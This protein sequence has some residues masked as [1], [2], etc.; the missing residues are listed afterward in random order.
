MLSEILKLLEEHGR[1]SLAEL[2]NHFGMT[3]DALEPT[4]D[5]LLR[6]GR[7]YL[8]DAECSS[9]GSCRGCS[10]ADRKEMLIYKIAEQ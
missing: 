6:K 10:C 8:L 1:L 7:V 4:M 3:A 5:I 2:M 9:G